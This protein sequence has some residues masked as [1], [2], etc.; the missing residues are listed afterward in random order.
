MVVLALA[1]ATPAHAAFPGQNGKIAFYRNVGSDWD[2]Y[3]INPDGTGETNLTS[4][5]TGDQE[6]PAWSPDDGTGGLFMTQGVFVP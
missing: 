5:Q 3:V 2:V 6:S 4:S 1:L